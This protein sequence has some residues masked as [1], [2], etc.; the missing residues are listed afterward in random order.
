MK[1]EDI[2]SQSNKGLNFWLCGG[3]IAILAASTLSRD[4]TRPFYGMHSWGQA[5][6]AWVARSHVKYG[7]GY[8]KGFDTFA[9]GYPPPEK[10]S[11]YL[12]HPVLFTLVDS[13]AMVIL[14]INTWAL[15]IMNVLATVTAILLFL[16]ILRGLMDETTSLLAGL[17][18]AMVP[19]I[20]YFG[21][22][23]W[24]YPLCFGA[25]WCYLVLIGGLKNG[26]P[27]PQK[28]HK[29]ILAACLFLAIQM[30]WEGFFFAMAL[31]I[32]YVSRCLYRR[33]LPDW[34][35]IAILALAP[36]ASLL[37]DFTILAAGSGWNF[38]RIFQLYKVRS[39]SG[40]QINLS[41]ADWFLRFW[42]H[43]DTNFTLPILFLVIAYLTLGQLLVFAPIEK[44]AQSVSRRFPHFWL[45]LM[46][47]V[48]QL[49]ILR[50]TLYPHQ[51]WERP[52]TPFISIA[53]ALG[54]MVVYDALKKIHQWLAVGGAVAL[55]GILFTFCVIG[56]N[57]YYGIRWQ[58]EGRIEMFERLGKMIPPDKAL[59]SFDAF[60]IDQFPGIKEASYRPEVA[61]YI[62]REIVPAQKLEDI[63]KYAKTG[64]FPYYLIPITGTSQQETAYID[65][66][67][68]QLEQKYKGSYIYY[69]Q[70]GEMKYGRFFRAAHHHISSSN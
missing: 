58:A 36:F 63:E 26:A 7:L 49:L 54:V 32:H 27:E 24:L 11:R 37:V 41:W 30:T 67:I 61:W 10:P 69:G 59:L 43:A 48:F 5:H 56:T 16:K 64:K 14:G 45:F 12:D 22:N 25:F 29:W 21:V 8:T 66:L 65:K 4:I 31:G 55:V 35:L 60:I 62:D 68:P 34:S 44:S 38:E 52:L 70:Q 57:Y 1:K 53:A 47:P 51:Y 18:F 46:P 19:L 39:G 23:M 42:E 9:V 50:G 33:R 13:L 20:G 2:S 3:L 28:Y 40:E 6:D 17:F 15:R